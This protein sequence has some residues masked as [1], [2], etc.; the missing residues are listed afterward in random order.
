L[1]LAVA[2][3]VAPSFPDNIST[4]LA[5]NAMLVGVAALGA[6]RFARTRLDWPETGAALF[7]LASALA[8]PV[9]ALSGAV[10]SEPLFLAALWP[11]L[12]AAERAVEPTGERRDALVAGVAI[13][14]LL[15]VR[16]H[17]IALLA[18]LVVTLVVRRRP[19]Q[20]MYAT[21][22]AAVVTL[23]W[24]LWMMAA[25]PALAAPL[26][27]AYGSYLGWFVAGLREG[28]LPFLAA[29]A[30]INL[31]ELWLLLQDRVVPGNAA[32]ARMLATSLLLALIVVGAWWVAR[33]APVIAWFLALY[34]AIVVVWP[35]TPWRF[36]WA[37]WPIVLL[38]AAAG[39][40]HLWSA[41]SVA[42]MRAV[43]TLVVALPAFGML[44][45]EASS[46]ATRA[47]ATP[48]LQAGAQITPF[49]V[50]VGRN[51]RPT[52]VVA[53]EGEQ[54]ISLFTGRRA[55]PTMPFTAREYVVARGRAENTA[56]LTEILD[57]IPAQYVL[58]M[59][60][61]TLTAA[62]ALAVP[63]SGIHSR[64]NGTPRLALTDKRQTDNIFTVLPE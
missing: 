13:G 7:A 51:T 57:Q 3:R 23:P 39:A 9:L 46:Y 58:A 27:G 36:L 45:T 24:Q 20:A 52:D 31:A 17:A 5:I 55:V 2:W 35:F 21:A 18:S 64:G 34:L 32:F 47:W 14:V 26:Q 30:R 25:T 50:W 11:A 63:P 22:A 60:P 38:C 4:F 15:L 6:Y 42:W 33:R 48:A 56:A 59:T 29:T 41:A 53:V 19:A 10:L 28:G 49:I 61:P 37:V 8:T 43:V 12:F 16:T 54:V 40:W 44:R 62:Q 1:L